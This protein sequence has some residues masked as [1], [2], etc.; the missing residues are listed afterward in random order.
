M[1][2]HGRLQPDIGRERF[3]ARPTAP[4]SDEASPLS[5]PSS[6]A[7][8]TARA[9]GHPQ[10]RGARPAPPVGTGP[11]VLARPWP[12]TCWGPAA[13]EAGDGG[14]GWGGDQKLRV[15]ARTAR[16]AQRPH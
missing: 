7:H 15:L 10:G 9:A 11:W 8:S 4:D 5:H 13:L 6:G 12:P 3:N 2:E 14:Q 16:P 1:M